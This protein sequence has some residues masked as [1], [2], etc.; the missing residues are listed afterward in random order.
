[1]SDPNPNRK[2]KEGLQAKKGVRMLCNP[3]PNPNPKDKEGMQAK[4]GVRMSPPPPPHHHHH[5]LPLSEPHS[6]TCPTDSL[7]WDNP[8][9]SE[10]GEG[11]FLDSIE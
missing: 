4:Q 7:D 9:P 1:L 10:V 8:P 6:H 3:N 11:G 5:L 2:D